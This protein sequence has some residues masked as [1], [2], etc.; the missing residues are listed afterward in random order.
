MII[1]N[2]FQ[3]IIKFLSLSLSFVSNFHDR[4]TKWSVEISIDDKQGYTLWWIGFRGTERGGGRKR[5]DGKIHC[6]GF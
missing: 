2:C 6:G 5:W 3:I 1:G 4:G